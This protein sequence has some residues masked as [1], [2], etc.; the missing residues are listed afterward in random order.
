MAATCCLTNG[1][2]EPLP[3]IRRVPVQNKVTVVLGTQWGDEGKGKV[4]DLLATEA[5]IVCRV[6]VFC[7]CK[8]ILMLSWLCYVLHPILTHIGCSGISI[9]SAGLVERFETRKL[10]RLTWW[11]E[12]LIVSD[13]AHIVFGFHQKIDGLLEAM[14]GHG[15]LGTTKKGIGPTY[16]SKAGRMGLRVS[17]LMGSQEGFEKKFRALAELYQQQFP[18][19]EINIDE[20]L[21]NYKTY[22]VELQPMVKDVVHYMNEQIHSN[23]N[24]TILIEGANATM[25]DI[26]FGTYPYVT[27]SNC[28]VGGVCTGLGIPPC[29]VGD[30]VGIVKAYTSRVGAGP[31]PTEQLNEIGDT[32]QKVGH[33][34]G[35]TTGRPRRCGWLDLV[36]VKYS[37]VLNNLT[38]VAITK[39][40]I[41]DGFDEIKIGVAY[42]HNG[43]PLPLFPASLEVLS[44]V[45]VDYITM[46]GWG[47][48][49]S[50]CRKYED[51]PKNAKKYLSTIQEILNVP[52]KW[53]GVGQSR[54]AII[55]L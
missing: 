36:I 23:D 48:P 43:K 6:Q 1:S 42:K 51:L 19:L 7:C 15:K 31:F 22:K 49:T 35:V 37:H 12:N 34:F 38:S 47:T 40:D 5:D 10:M 29:S 30:V 26:D 33:E 3:K 2:D 14:K 55:K 44:E 9:Q 32:L 18:D 50:E 45:E 52:V 39:L 17:D 16:S 20:E 8:Y 25:L 27:S 53:V 41:L 28:T 54:S 46:P 4:V 21:E 11:R 24:K 13:R